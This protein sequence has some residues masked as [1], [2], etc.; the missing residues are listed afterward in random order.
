MRPW[1]W[2]GEDLSLR[3]GWEGGIVWKPLLC[4]DLGALQVG[5]GQERTPVLTSSLLCSTTVGLCI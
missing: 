3:G 5:E 1:N 4:T 2:W